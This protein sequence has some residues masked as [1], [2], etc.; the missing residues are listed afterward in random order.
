MIV[1]SYALDVL[2]SAIFLLALR[3]K[4]TNVMNFHY[5]IISYGVV[6]NPLVVNAA[7]YSVLI[8]EALHSHFAFVSQSV[9]H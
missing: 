5:E 3:S 4:A 6:Y 1:F 8:S 2:F 9:T 7:A